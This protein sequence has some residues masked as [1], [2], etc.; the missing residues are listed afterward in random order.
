MK[1]LT[2]KTF[3]NKGIDIYIFE[4]AICVIFILKILSPMLEYMVTCD[5]IYVNVF[6]YL[7]DDSPYVMIILFNFVLIN[8]HALTQ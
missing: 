6:F 1:I 3:L 7:L 4:V 8:F 2:L 5:I